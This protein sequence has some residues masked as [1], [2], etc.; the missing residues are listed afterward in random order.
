VAEALEDKDMSLIFLL[1]ALQHIQLLLVL[2]EARL[3]KQAQIIQQN[4]VE[5]MVV[6][7]LDLLI[8][9]QVEVQVIMEE[10]VLVVLEAETQVLE[11]L[12]DMIL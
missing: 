11:T 12:G 7:H 8:L 3:L 2:G 9:L 10:V 6:I 5:M 4:L 1:Q